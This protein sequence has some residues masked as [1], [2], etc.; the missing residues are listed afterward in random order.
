MYS[1]KP[2]TGRVGAVATVG[3]ADHVHDDIPLQGQV[4]DDGAG[5]G[6][7]SQKVLIAPQSPFA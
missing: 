7:R 1:P 4:V 5:G 6:C 3:V 2:N